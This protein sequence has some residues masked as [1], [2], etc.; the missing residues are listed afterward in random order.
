MTDKEKAEKTLRLFNHALGV[1]GCGGK[2]KLMPV[3]V[4]DWDGASVETNYSVSIDL[5]TAAQLAAVISTLQACAE[6]A[7]ALF[8][9]L[10]TVKTDMVGL[11]LV[12]DTTDLDELKEIVARHPIRFKFGPNPVVVGEDAAVVLNQRPFTDED[13]ERLKAYVVKERDAPR[14]GSVFDKYPKLK[15]SAE[16]MHGIVSNFY[17]D[18]QYN[19]AVQ[20]EFGLA[21]KLGGEFLALLKTLRGTGSDWAK[22][23][24]AEV[25]I[26]TW[27]RGLGMNLDDVPY[28]KPADKPGPEGGAQGDAC[29][30]DCKELGDSEDTRI[31]KWFGSYLGSPQKRCADC[32]EEFTR[33]EEGE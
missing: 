15:G 6:T 18:T 21:K 32:V 23:S 19:A 25:C 17:R 2:A 28:E 22:A 9:P 14:V 1:T 20:A 4:R 13:A 24:T 31:C 27:A 26:S 11:G 29:P 16:R 33:E 30:P 8:H 12:G 7:F 3:A 5:R 10:R